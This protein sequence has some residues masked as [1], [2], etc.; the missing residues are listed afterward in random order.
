MPLAV[1]AHILTFAFLQVWAQESSQDHGPLGPLSNLHLHSSSDPSRQG[2]RV[3][4]VLSEDSGDQ[5][6]TDCYTPLLVSC[7]TLGKSLSLSEP[8]FPQK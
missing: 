2:G 1:P 5:G 8:Q 4:Q 3:G 6:A 7:V